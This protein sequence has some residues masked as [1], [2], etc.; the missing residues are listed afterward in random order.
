MEQPVA[1]AWSSQTGCF[2][3]LASNNL[4]VRQN[5]FEVVG[6]AWLEIEH[7]EFSCSGCFYGFTSKIV[8]VVSFV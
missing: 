1:L 6:D 7:F 2:V 8:L 3:V 4:A 5:Y